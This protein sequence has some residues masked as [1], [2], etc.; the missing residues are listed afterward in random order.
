MRGKLNI[1][2]VDR[3]TG[4]REVVYEAYNLNFGLLKVL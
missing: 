3:A 4:E 1:Q 2:R